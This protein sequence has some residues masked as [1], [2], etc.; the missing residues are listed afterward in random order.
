MAIATASG[1]STPAYANPAEPAAATVQVSQTAPQEPTLLAASV[2]GQCRRSNTDNLGIF[3][4]P[5]STTG[6][7]VDVVPK[8]GVVRLADDGSKGWIKVDYPKE[9]YVQ[10]N[11]LYVAPCPPDLAQKPTPG[12]TNL[13]RRIITPPE[14]L[15]IRANP[16]SSS[17]LVG[18]VAQYQ[19]VTLSTSPATTSKDSAGRTWIQV[20]APARGWIS[21][22]LPGSA[23]HVV[24]CSASVPNPQPPKPPTTG[25]RCRRV[26]NPPEGLLIT[27]EAKTGSGVVGGVAQYEK[28]TLT[29][30]PPTTSKESSGRTWVQVEAPASGWVSNGFGAQSNLGVCP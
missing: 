20:S 3:S 19:T 7:R 4:G 13:C 9:G 11:S 15:V 30:D 22:G 6:T 28:V 25:S 26:I 2:V 21:N 8:N 16:T 12:D 24:Y 18:G 10:A 27:R 5:A 29:T 23:G 14:G 17:A 1:L